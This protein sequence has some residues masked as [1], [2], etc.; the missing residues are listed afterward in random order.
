MK[1]MLENETVMIEKKPS[2]T[3]RKKI[4]KWAKARA[5]ET[6]EKEKTNL[7]L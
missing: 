6:F 4:G 2:E 5:D 1:K 7:S 3:A